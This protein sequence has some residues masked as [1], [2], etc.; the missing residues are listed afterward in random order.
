VDDPDAAARLRAAADA[1]GDDPDSRAA[2]VA[3][4]RE[5]L[6]PPPGA[7]ADDDPIPLTLS[8]G[9]ADELFDLVREGMVA[10]VALAPPTLDDAGAAAGFSLGGLNPFTVARTVVNTASYYRMKDRAGKVG[11]KGITPLVRELTERTGRPVTLVGHSFGARAATAAVAAG[12]PAHALCLLQGAFSHVA[13]TERSPVGT[14]G[15]FRAVLAG[16]SF[17]GP[18]V[19]T[20]THND[21]AVLLAYAIA[22]RVA[23]QVASDVGDRN[24]PYGGIGANGALGLAAA[25]VDDSVPLGP[26]DTAYTFTGHRVHNLRADRFVSGHSDITGPEVANAVYQAVTTR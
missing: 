21:R 13:F 24:D 25:E 14:P 22:S 11:A 8:E 2:F 10:A 19:V 3:A 17:T 12:A 26:A 23:K 16:G 20:H 18:V 4:V 1:L 6:L 15:A 5:S 7:V 9:D